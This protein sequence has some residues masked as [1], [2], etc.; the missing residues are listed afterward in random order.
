MLKKLNNEPNKEENENGEAEKGE[1][2]DIKPS[3]LKEFKLI[4][5]VIGEFGMR[6]IF[7]KQILWKDEGLNEFLAKIND[8]LDYKVINNGDINNTNNKSKSDK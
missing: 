3:L 5:D 2:E 6:K 8:V 1:L 7:S 4:A